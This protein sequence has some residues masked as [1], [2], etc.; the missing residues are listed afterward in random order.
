MPPSTASREGQLGAPV[1]GLAD[2]R[3]VITDDDSGAGGV[4]PEVNN[5][6]RFWHADSRERHC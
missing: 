4:G 5:Q 3:R 6:H 2:E 1:K